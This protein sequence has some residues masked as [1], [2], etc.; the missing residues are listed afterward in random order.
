MAKLAR[1]VVDII[2]RCA[3]SSSITIAVE[4]S[5]RH[6]PM[7]KAAA[8]GWPS[9]SAPSEIASADRNACSPPNP[10][11]RRRMVS[12]RRIESSRPMK[13]RRKTI[14]KSAMKAICFS[15]V[16]VIQSMARE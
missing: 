10:K 13:K 3:E 16:T 12:K 5:A 14:P 7:I 4:E 6:E 11:T 9:H 8:A 2:R 15:P 1:P